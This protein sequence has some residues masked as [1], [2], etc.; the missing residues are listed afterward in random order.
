MYCSL[1]DL[2]YGSPPLL[3]SSFSIQAAAWNT[4]LALSLSLKL[5]SVKSTVQLSIF[6]QESVLD[7]NIFP[8][9]IHMLNLVADFFIPHLDLDPSNVKKKCLACSEGWQPFR[10]ASYR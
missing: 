5:H 3:G 6:T 9:W 7:W 1:A 4:D 2:L 10:M 8:V